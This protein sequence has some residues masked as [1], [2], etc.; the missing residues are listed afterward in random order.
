VYLFETGVR[1]REALGQVL[2]FLAHGRIEG[3]ISRHINGAMTRDD[4]S[5]AIRRRHGRA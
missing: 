4:L 2:G 3:L 1:H 5:T